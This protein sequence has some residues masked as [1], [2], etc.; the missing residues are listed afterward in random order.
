MKKSILTLTLAV[1]MVFISGCQE[2]QKQDVKNVLTQWQDAYAKQDINGIMAVYSEDYRGSQGEQKAQVREFLEDMKSQG[3][4]NNTKMNIKD[5][6]IEVD[7]DIAT[8]APITYTGD[9]GQMDIKNTF[10]KE[11]STWRTISGEEY[12]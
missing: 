7:G 10:K 6:Q 8:V 11:G 3:Y 5:I 4:L 12:Y 1:L 9:W 2:S